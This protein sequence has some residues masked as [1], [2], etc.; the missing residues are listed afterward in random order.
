MTRRSERGSVSVEF[1][2]LV[3]GLILVLGLVVAGGRLWFAR[4]AVSE[5]SYSAARG[6]SL[7]R[8]AADAS[9]DGAAA[10][11]AALASRGLECTAVSVSVSTAAFA[12][13]VGR[14]ATIISRVSCTVGFGDVLLP[15]LP[16]SITLEAT[17]SSALDTYR[18]R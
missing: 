9:S 4:S 5:A 10:G 6:A 11:R 1:A 2:L 17:G 7:A 12:V 8:T 3:P 16:G 14:P 18:A 15:G 13:P